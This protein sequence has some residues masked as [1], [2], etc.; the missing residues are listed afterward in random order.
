MKKQTFNWVLIEERFPPYA[1]W[2]DK[3]FYLITYIKKGRP[4]MAVARY[5][6]PCEL[7]PN[8]IT[9]HNFSFGKNNKQ[10]VAWA[11]GLTPYC[12]TAGI[13]SRC[14]KEGK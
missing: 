3:V 12:G 13:K 4:Q 11:E 10:I 1:K 9:T 14:L 8:E 2:N 7:E 5:W 6:E